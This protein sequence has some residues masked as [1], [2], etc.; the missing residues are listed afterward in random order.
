[1]TASRAQA[2]LD[3]RNAMYLERAGALKDALMNAGY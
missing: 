2:E 3:A 1:V